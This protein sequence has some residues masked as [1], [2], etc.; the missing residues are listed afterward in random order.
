MTNYIYALLLLFI[1]VTFVLAVFAGM[2]YRTLDRMTYNRGTVIAEYEAPHLL[3]PAELGYLYD[4]DFGDNELL[5][6]ILTLVRN[7][8]V[9]IVSHEPHNP[10]FQAKDDTK[11]KDLQELDDAGKA[12]YSWIRSQKHKNIA[13][14]DISDIFS[15]T[16]GARSSYE[17]DVHNAL[18]HKNYIRKGSVLS[19]RNM[20]AQLYGSFGLMLV[21]LAV[22]SYYFIS[23]ARLTGLNDDYQSL[24]RFTGIAIFTMASALLWLPVA[25]LMKLITLTYHFSAGQPANMTPKF[26]KHWHDVAG[27]RLFVSTVEFSRLSAD[28]NP[29]DKAMPYAIALGFR[30][31]INKLTDLARRR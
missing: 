11:D 24:D 14:K 27:F 10:L 21:L 30:P 17:Q 29:Y 1:P 19:A 16:L 5:A 18:V 22:A 8:L 3:S 31:D 4:K 7:G 13:W 12:V 2:L 25:Y 6:T 26:R 15:A 23:S 28:T 9:Y 20:H